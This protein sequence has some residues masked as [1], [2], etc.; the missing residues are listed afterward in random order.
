MPGRLAGLDPYRLDGS[1]ELE[2]VPRLSGAHSPG[3]GAQAR[4]C[5]LGALS[6]GTLDQREPRWSNRGR[7]AAQLVT[8]QELG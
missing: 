1:T 8:K 7:A 3:V 5:S 4:R 6:V 2:M